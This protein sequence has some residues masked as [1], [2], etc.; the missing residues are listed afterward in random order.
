MKVANIEGAPLDEG[1]PAKI[2][3]LKN[4]GLAVM[5]EM[6]IKDLREVRN[7]IVHYGELP[8]KAQAVEALKIA[9]KVLD[10]VSTT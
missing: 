7:R 4:K 10:S 6:Q 3:R 1:I 5:H 9:Q 2:E 8:N